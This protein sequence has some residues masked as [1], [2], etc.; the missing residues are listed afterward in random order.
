V[1]MVV[2]VFVGGDGRGAARP[3]KKM[4]GGWREPF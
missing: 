3:R 1:V 2:V 4:S